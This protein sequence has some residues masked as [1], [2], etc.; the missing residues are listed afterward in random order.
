MQASEAVPGDTL[1]FV[2]P[3]VNATLKEHEQLA[4]TLIQCSGY[5]FLL[6]DLKSTC[7]AASNVSKVAGQSS[8]DRC[9]HATIMISSLALY[10]PRAVFESNRVKAVGPAALSLGRPY[11]SCCMSKRTL[12]TVYDNAVNSC[13]AGTL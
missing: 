5:C 9:T 8:V 11:N 1:T 3:C 7:M 4:S 13:T 6:E 12:V 2:V 10:A